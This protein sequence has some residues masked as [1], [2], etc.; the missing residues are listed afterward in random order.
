MKIRE[1]KPK[2]YIVVLRRMLLLLKEKRLNFVDFG[3][4]N[5]LLLEADWDSRHPAYCCVTKSD[6]ELSLDSSCDSSTINRRK[7][8]LLNLGLIEIQDGLVKIIDFQKFELSFARQLAKKEVANLQED[9]AQTQSLIVE[10]H[11]SNVEMQ[12]SQVQN[13]SQNFSVSSKGNLNSSSKSRSEIDI[14]E[15]SKLIDNDDDKY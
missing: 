7:Q 12:T 10:M 6:L 4:Y 15:I 13:D 1:L 5:F 11:K 8:R 2:G 14:D 3:F 9:T